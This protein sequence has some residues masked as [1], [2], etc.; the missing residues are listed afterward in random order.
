MPG[1]SLAYLVSGTGQAD[2]LWRALEIEF[3][4]ELLFG[5]I[6]ATWNILEQSA[7]AVLTAAHQAGVGVIIKE[8]LANG[9]LTPRNQSPDFQ[10]KWTPSTQ[11]AQAN[12]TTVDA[13]ASSRCP[14]PAV[15]RCRPQW[16]GSESIIFTET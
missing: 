13:L 3:D 12:H 10:P 5:S 15:C 1:T 6:Q 11:L 16:S 8:A 2:T 14:Q 4:G 9:R 7:T